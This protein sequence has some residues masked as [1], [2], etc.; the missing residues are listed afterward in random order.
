MKL[1]FIGTGEI[2][3]AMVTGFCTAEPRPN[4]VWV[5]PRNAGKAARLAAAFPEVEVAAS[6]Q[7]VVERSDWLVVAVLPQIVRDV[8]KPLGFAAGQRVVSVVPKLPLDELAGYVAPAEPLAQVLPLPPAAR[9]LGPI[10]ICPPEAE[11]AALFGRIGTIVQVEDPR[12]FDAFWSA[13]A[14]MAP[15]YGLLS[16]AADWLVRQGISGVAGG[17]YIGAMFHALAENAK[18]AG[19]EGFRTLTAESQTPGG[20]NEQCYRE[21]GAAGWYDSVDQGLDGI[22]ARLRGA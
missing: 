20:L 22:L 21:L 4:Q 6:N 15:Y 8:L 1:G 13:T 14:L 12:Q 9:H 7:E 10:A 2:T 5:S 3:V 11:T 18:E 16:R 19:A 17:R